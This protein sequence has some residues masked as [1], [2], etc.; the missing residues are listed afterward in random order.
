MIEKAFKKCIRTGETN[1]YDS[2]VGTGSFLAYYNLG[3]FYE[4]IGNIQDAIEYYQKSSQLEY[5]PAK[6]RL[7]RLKQCQRPN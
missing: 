2:V 6:D 3:A 7:F 1:Q 5:E 4:G